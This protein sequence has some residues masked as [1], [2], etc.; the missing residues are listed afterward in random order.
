MRYRH[1][2]GVFLERIDGELVVCEPLSGNVYTLAGS[3]AVIFELCSANTGEYVLA[4]LAR[5]YP[6]EPVSKLAT[7]RD[8]FTAELSTAGLLAMDDDPWPR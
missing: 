6:D 7:H 1:A 2:D 4:E 5:Q 8:R 3:G